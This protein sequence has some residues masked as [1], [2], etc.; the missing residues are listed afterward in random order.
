MYVCE[1][2]GGRFWLISAPERPRAQGAGQITRWTSGAHSFIHH[3]SPPSSP[4]LQPHAG[5]L[6]ALRCP[7][8]PVLAPGVSCWVRNTVCVPRPYPS[9]G[10]TLFS[11][12]KH[13]QSLHTPKLHDKTPQEAHRKQPRATAISWLPAQLMRQGGCS[14]PESEC[15]GPPGSPRPS[16]RLWLG[17]F[18][19]L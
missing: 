6:P 3:S 19:H 5:Q 7:L 16:A 14:R 10:R 13:F 4:A 18:P 15:W 11:C 9:R 12:H 17:L 8:P 1:K 2:K